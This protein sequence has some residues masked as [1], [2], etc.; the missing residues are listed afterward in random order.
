MSKRTIILIV[1]LLLVTAGLLAI[2]LAPKKA[3]TPEKSAPGT[4]ATPDYAHS[5]LS[6][7]QPVLT[8]AGTYSSSV[9][10]DTGSNQVTGVQLELSFD[11]TKLQIV[12]IKPSTFFPTAAEL[13]VKKIDNVNGTISYALIAGIGKAG[14]S[15]SGDVAVITFRQIGKT[16]DTAELKFEAKSL[17]TAAERAE[18]VMDKAVDAVF[19]IGT[20]APENSVPSSST[21]SGQ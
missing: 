19:T 13:G 17:V 10:I 15:G 21:P 4:G 8:P 20:P 12:D 7:A 2:A 5:V 16:G 18:S 1:V 6:I 11:P 9:S 14:V 3:P